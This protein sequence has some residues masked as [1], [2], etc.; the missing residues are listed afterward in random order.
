MADSIAKHGANTWFT[1][2]AADLLK[3]YE[4]TSDPDAPPWLT[5]AAKHHDRSRPVITGLTK[6]TDI[7]DVWFESGSSWHAAVRQR[8]LARPQGPL[9]D[10]YL[11]GSDQHRGWFQLSLL[12]SL[13]VTGQSPFKT[14]LTHGF[15]VDKN[16][17]K[18]SKSLGN[19]LDVDDLLKKFG[20]DVCR[21]W[22]SSLNTDNDIKV[23]RQFFTL[24]GEEYRKVRNTIRFL[25]S[26]LGDFDPGHDR[27]TDTDTDATSPN[28]WALGELTTLVWVVVDAYDCYQFR[29][30]HEALFN[31]CNDTMSAVYLA[32]M[33]DRLYC[34]SPVSRRR[35]HAQTTIHT[36]ADGLIR[37]L[38][39]LMPH[40]ADEAWRAL[41][42]AD[43]PNVHLEP[44]PSP[45]QVVADP[46]WPQVLE[47][48]DTW[49]KT[50]EAARQELGIDNPLDCGLTIPKTDWLSRFNP[51]DL[52]DLCGISRCQLALVDAPKVQDLRDQPR[53]ERSW[54][55]DGTVKRRSDGGMLGDRDAEA[56]GLV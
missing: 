21:W 19:T 37:L 38:A 47:A 13:G 56:L 17:R 31:F 39:P 55:R 26:N 4:P 12:P 42:G 25:L 11:E 16:G 53:C 43:A 2:S 45:P 1:A 7:F 3:T 8:G 27:C 18:M 10:L 23:D 20:A 50:I 14:V 44:L 54:K 29:R 49:L 46:D 34:D 9:T 30:A 22:V 48:R 52:A 6:S 5:E 36:I 40:T 24:A 32:A 41:H 35:R 51:V 28:A 15:M 33:K